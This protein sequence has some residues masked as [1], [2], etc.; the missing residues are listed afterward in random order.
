MSELY[1]DV[2]GQGLTLGVNATLVSAKV[3]RPNEELVTAS[4]VSSAAP[5][6]W[7]ASVPYAIT[8]EDGEFFIEWTYTV[9]GNQY[10]RTETHEVVTPLIDPTITDYDAEAERYVRRVIEAITGQNFGFYTGVKAVHAQGDNYLRLEARLIEVAAV[11]S[12][13][14]FST[15]LERGTVEGDG[16][17]YVNRPYDGVELIKPNDFPLTNATGTIVVEGVIHNPWANRRYRDNTI[18]YINGSWGYYSVP[19]NIRMAAKLL[20]DDFQCKDAQYR[21]KYLESMRSGDWRIEF[22]T[23]AYHGTGNLVADQLLEPYK[24]ESMFIV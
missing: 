5:N 20:Y 9:E 16:W 18:Y 10:T 17:L 22:K 8:H 23:M 4:V 19:E 15:T 24:K 6:Y 11:S 3:G 1:R 13:P 12:E 2:T 14:D 7:I 21:N